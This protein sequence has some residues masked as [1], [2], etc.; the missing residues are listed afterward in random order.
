MHHASLDGAIELKTCVSFRSGMYCVIEF[1]YTVHTTT[2]R[3]TSFQ[4]NSSIQ[5]GMVQR[6]TPRIVRDAGCVT[7][8]VNVL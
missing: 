4:L 8:A 7:A 3:H 6:V 1:Y 2:E 5:T